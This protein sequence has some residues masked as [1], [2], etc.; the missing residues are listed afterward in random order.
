MFDPRARSSAALQW[1]NQW[2]K[3]AISPK[4]EVGNFSKLKPSF[5]RM[6]EMT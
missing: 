4:K 5:H 1:N 3:F 2:L 6:F